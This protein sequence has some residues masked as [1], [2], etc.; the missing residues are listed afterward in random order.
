MLYVA[1]WLKETHGRATITHCPQLALGRE[2][3]TL[4]PPY[5]AGIP[6][7]YFWMALAEGLGNPWQ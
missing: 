3:V 1:G 5:R 4:L 2:Q 6:R 7:V